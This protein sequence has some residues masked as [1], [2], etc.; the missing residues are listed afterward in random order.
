MR[1]KTTALASLLLTAFLTGCGG[2]GGSGTSQASSYPL[3]T[4]VMNVFGAAWQ[5]SGV[6]NGTYTFL[7]TNPPPGTGGKCSTAVT[8]TFTNTVTPG[9]AANLGGVVANLVSVSRVQVNS[10]SGGSTVSYQVGVKPDFSAIV[11]ASGCTIAIPDI[12]S[13]G[14]T[15]ILSCPNGTS[16][17]GITLSVSADKSSGDAA[18]TITS[19]FGKEVFRL[20]ANGSVTPVSIGP[21]SVTSND[22]FPSTLTYTLLY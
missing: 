19:A 2:G 5:K 3:R 17:N 8:G 1:F 4:G 6:V 10:V 12:V 18:V 13:I 14:Y 20:S 9:S 15:A 11:D 22:Q 16:S 21:F 7:C